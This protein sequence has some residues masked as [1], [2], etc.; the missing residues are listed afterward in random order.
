MLQV[1]HWQRTCS[2][3]RFESKQEA[4]RA[5]RLSARRRV[6]S[7]ER[8]ADEWICGGEGGDAAF[9]PP[10][11]AMHC[12]NRPDA[13]RGVQRGRG[14]GASPATPSVRGGGP[15]Q[16]SFGLLSLLRRLGDLTA[17]RRFLLHAFDHAHRHRL[18]HVAD[19]EAP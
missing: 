14:V 10:A 4:S 12:D 3:C 8:R 1:C 16:R 7:C 18:A 6:A 19:G 2:C 9:P 5:Q 11:L 13:E 17:G 15:A